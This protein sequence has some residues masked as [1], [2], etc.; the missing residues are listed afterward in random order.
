M[1]NAI[2]IYG[3]K[4]LTLLWF[5]NFIFYSFYFFNFFIFIGGTYTMKKDL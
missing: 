3:V 2:Y 5:K 4:Y 1:S